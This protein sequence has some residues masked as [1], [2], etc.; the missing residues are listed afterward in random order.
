MSESVFSAREIRQLVGGEVGHREV[1]LAGLRPA[2]HVEAG[3]GRCAGG[4]PGVCWP[5]IDIDDVLAPLVHQ[6]GGGVAPHAIQPAANQRK[7]IGGE[8]IYGWGEIDLAGK[9]GFHRV[10]VGGGNLDDMAGHERA[11]MG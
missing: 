6:D 10:P 1:P 2:D 7:A 11:H 9:P 4:A 3:P 5:D 8:V